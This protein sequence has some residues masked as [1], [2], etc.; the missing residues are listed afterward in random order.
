MN[1]KR[2]RP[3]MLFKIWK[4]DEVAEC[5]NG[6][7]NT[8]LYAKLWTF[9]NDYKGLPPEQA[10]EPTPGVDCLADFWSRLD[11]DEKVKLNELA[12]RHDEEAEADWG[13]NTRR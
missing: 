10:E 11:Y 12:K 5:L 8:D 9:V 6:V 4:P 3:H 7:G 13:M 2:V 1:A